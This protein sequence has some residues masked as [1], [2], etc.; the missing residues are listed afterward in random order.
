MPLSPPSLAG[1]IQGGL[2]ASSIAGVS[3]ASLALGIATGV[4]Q[5]IPTIVV[6]TTDA[7]A[8]GTGTGTLPLLVQPGLLQGGF[9]AG[10]AAFSGTALPQLITGLATGLSNGLMSAMIITVHP[11]VGVGTGVPQFICQ[12]A[13]PMILA[14]LL[15]A[16]IKGVSASVLAQGIGT[17][18]QQAFSS[19]VLAIPIA[20]VVYPM[21]GPTV[22]TGTIA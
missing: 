15:G 6:L 19:L 14:G 18:L 7:G 3:A 8:P 5:W 4:C 16:G 2:S 20:G 13:F 10:L 9:Q 1:A 12:P 17:G 11:C 22:G 21:T